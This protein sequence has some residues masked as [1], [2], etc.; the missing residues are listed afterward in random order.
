MS[1]DIS[2]LQANIQAEVAAVG[3]EMMRPSVLWKPTLLRY[4]AGYE[5][6]GVIVQWSATYGSCVG[7]GDSPDAAMRNFDKRWG[8]KA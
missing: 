8:E 5:D 6:D 2:W 7:L 1:V 4:E 3:Y